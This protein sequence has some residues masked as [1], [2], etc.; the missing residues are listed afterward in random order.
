MSVTSGQMIDCAAA[1]LTTASDEAQFRSVCS[2]AYYGAFHA[3]NNF[4]NALPVPGTVGNAKG[5]H[6][7]L[8][9]QLTNPQISKQNKRYHVSQALA[10]SLR[11]LLSNRVLADYTVAKTVGRDLADATVIGARVVE[12]EAI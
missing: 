6:E 7:Q 9:A 8:I 11:P 5:R 4:H 3:A 12:R 2:R 10:K 1:M